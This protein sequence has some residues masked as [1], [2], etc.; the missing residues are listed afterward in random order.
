MTDA[1]VSDFSPLLAWADQANAKPGDA[2]TT[3]TVSVVAS[4]VQV[5]AKPIIHQA[6]RWNLAASCFQTISMAAQNAQHA[7]IRDDPKNARRYLETIHAQA[8]AALFEL[9]TVNGVAP[10]R[11]TQQTLGVGPP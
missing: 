6:G 9:A 2:G 7:I 4:G 1:V 5:P 3:E 11:I 8:D 10:P